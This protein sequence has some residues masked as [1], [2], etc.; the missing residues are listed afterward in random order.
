MK[1]KTKKLIAKEGLFFIGSFVVIWVYWA[2][3]KDARRLE[4]VLVW[5]MVNFI[6]RFFFWAIKTLKAK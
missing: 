4:I 2:F 6:I 3:R 1:L 5:L